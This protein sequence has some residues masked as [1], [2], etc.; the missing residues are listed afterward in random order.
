MKRY[1]MTV[2]ISPEM[3]D[4]FEALQKLAH[5]INIPVYRLLWCAWLA[6]RVKFEKELPKH[7]TVTIEGTEVTI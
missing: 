1:A 7:R 4:E 2:Y 5:A 3:L 6:C